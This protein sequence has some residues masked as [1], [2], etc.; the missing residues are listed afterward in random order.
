MNRK[1]KRELVELLKKENIE[2]T[3]HKGR[4]II[5]GLEINTKK[6]AIS[7]W[8]SV[9]MYWVSYQIANEFTF[10]NY[11]RLTDSPRDVIEWIYEYYVEIQEIELLMKSTNIDE[12]VDEDE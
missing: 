2:Y 7:M 1:L 12:E 9:D 4:I 6:V 8:L 3:E 11:Q 10:H 5:K